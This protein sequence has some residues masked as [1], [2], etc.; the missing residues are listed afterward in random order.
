MGMLKVISHQIKTLLPF[1]MVTF[2]S[3]VLSETESW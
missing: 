3:W 1:R 2:L